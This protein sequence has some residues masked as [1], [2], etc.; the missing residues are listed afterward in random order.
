MATTFTFSIGRGFE[1]EPDEV[2]PGPAGPVGSGPGSGSTDSTASR[3]QINS[4]R[5]EEVWGT[6]L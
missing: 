5:T 1:P 3:N 2:A 4:F 6:K